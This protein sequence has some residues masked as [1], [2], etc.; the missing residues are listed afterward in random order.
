MFRIV[1]GCLSFLQFTHYFQLCSAKVSAADKAE[2][3]GKSAAR[4]P[5]PSINRYT[6][7]E[8][9]EDEILRA[10]DKFF[11]FEGEGTVM[12]RSSNKEK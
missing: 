8:E 7:D 4:R 1:G 6:E 12:E 5:D 3:A 9:E 10:L 2:A 11:V